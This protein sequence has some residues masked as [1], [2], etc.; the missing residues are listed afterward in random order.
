MGSQIPSLKSTHVSKS[1]HQ[2]RVPTFGHQ[3][4]IKKQF[5]IIKSGS[6]LLHTRVFT[7]PMFRVRSTFL[8]DPTPNTSTK[9]HLQEVL[10]RRHP[11]HTWDFGLGTPCEVASKSQLLC[12]QQLRLHGLTSSDLG[13]RTW[14]SV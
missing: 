8:L 12:S 2:G 11:C 6:Y 10:P 14:D 3:E 5:I 4:T 7:G 1:Q 9:P 13:L